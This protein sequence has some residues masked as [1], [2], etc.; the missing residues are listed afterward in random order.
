[1][2]KTS[3]AGGSRFPKALAVHLNDYL[4]PLDPIEPADIIVTGAATAMHDVLAWAMADPGDGILMS[5]PVYGRFELDF[6][7]KSQVKVVYADT[8]AENSLDENVVDK[9]EEALQESTAEGTRILALLIVN[10]HNPLGKSLMLGK[11]SSPSHSSRSAI[12]IRDLP[13][14]MVA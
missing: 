13:A 2:Y 1:L 5:R 9:F 4:E 11:R 14:M 10:P 7:N 6:G 12:C 8:T 3:T